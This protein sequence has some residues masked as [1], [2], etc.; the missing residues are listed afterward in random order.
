[1][2]KRKAMQPRTDKKIFR[3]TASRTKKL[4]VANRN[5]RGG[6]RL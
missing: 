1:M 2:A 6:V 4:N 3:Q 5:F